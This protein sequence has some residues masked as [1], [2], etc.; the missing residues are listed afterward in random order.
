VPTDF[1]KDCITELRKE[2]DVFMLAE[3]DKGD[4]HKAGFDASYPWDMFQTMKKVAAGERNALSLDSV[5]M[6]QDTSF[7]AGAI[8]MYFTSNHDENSW[9]KSDY[10]T[11][12]GPKHAP[13]AVFTQTMAASLPLIYGGQEEPV[14]RPI[15][16]FEKDTMHFANYER[17]SFYK[18]L[19]DLRNK[20][21]ALAVDAD[22]KRIP[23]GDNK[24]LYAYV[25]QKGRSK[26]FVIL[27]FSGQEQPYSVKEI[28]LN[29]RP[30]NIFSGNNE[31]VDSTEKKL[32]PWGYLVYV[33]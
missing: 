13:F 1:W 9:N 2:K 12:P 7:P 19:L 20:N 14:L 27:N 33:Y 24:S 15:S 29:G 31:K 26:V 11:F 16:F 18:T 21:S 8:R 5:L 22:F 6:R 10:G 30:L 17:A 25:R 28:S 3:A 4:L 32:G 23:L